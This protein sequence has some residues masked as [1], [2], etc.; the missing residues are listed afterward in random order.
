MIRTLLALAFVGIGSAQ[1]EVPAFTSEESIRGMYDYGACVVELEPA[2]SRRVLTVPPG[3]TDERALLRKISTDR[4]V[5]GHGQVYHID[6]EPQMLRGVIAEVV[7][8]LDKDK[9]RLAAPFTGQTAEAIAA[10]DERGRSALG[11]LDF[12]ACIVGRAPDPVTAVL[13]TKPAS[14]KE[15][16][17]LKLLRPHLSPCLRAGAR[18]TIAKPQLR[19]FLAEA[20]YRASYAAAQGGR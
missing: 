6:Y 17:A 16:E 9:G 10:L 14:S 8:D 15:A 18:L 2:Q 5:S 11:A 1:A 19:G 3:S 13:R 12:A 20:A 7:L 4:C